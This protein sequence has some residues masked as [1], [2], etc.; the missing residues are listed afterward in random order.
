MFP[1][2]ELKKFQIILM[3]EFFVF[4][5]GSIFNFLLIRSNIFSFDFLSQNFG[6]FFIF[7]IFLRT[8]KNYSFFFPTRST[9][10]AKFQKKK[11]MLVGKVV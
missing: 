3:F 10:V 11:T 2:I 7:Y 8:C 6:N 5:V 9:K 4:R 1:N